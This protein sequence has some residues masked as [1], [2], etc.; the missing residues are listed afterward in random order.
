MG[1][2]ALSFPSTILYSETQK[3]YLGCFTRFIPMFNGKTA[4]Q[5]RSPEKPCPE[6]LVPEVISL[7]GG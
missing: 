5:D 4:E 1:F 2:F 7:A 6:D 3:L